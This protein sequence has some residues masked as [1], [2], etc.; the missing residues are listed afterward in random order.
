MMRRDV[1]HGMLVFLC[2]TGACVGVVSTA[3]AAELRVL[4]SAGLVR[5]LR[6]VKGAAKVTITLETQQPV[7]GECVASNV[8][9]LASEKREPVTPQKVCVF[10]D[11]AAGSWQIE[12][13]GKVRWRVQINE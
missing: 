6:V 10:K 2:V 12:V 13:P 8:D 3:S 11:L 7:R 4:D 1:R 9:G 5:A